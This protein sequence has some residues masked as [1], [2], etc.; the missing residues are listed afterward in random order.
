MIVYYNGKF[1]RKEEV[2]ISPDDRGFLFAD[3]VYDVIHA[4]AGRLFRCD[5]HLARFAHGM[6]ELR[7]KGVDSKALKEV[8]QQLLAENDLEKE[9]A[10]IYMQVTR[11]AAPRSHEFPPEGTP[12][13]VYVEAKPYSP[14][15]QLRENGAMAILVPDQRWSRCD[16]KSISLLPNILA[17]QKATEAGAFEA[18]FWGDGLL[19]EGTH[20][21]ILFVKGRRLVCP[22]LTN[23]LLPSV[24]RSV[25]I[26]LAIAESIRVD[27]R[28]CREGEL[29]E[30]DEI[31]MLGTGV[32]IVPITTINGRKIRHGMVG[33]ITRQLQSAFTRTVNSH[34]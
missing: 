17:H 10:L 28:P 18:I 4:Y 32:E 1:L 33:Q 13:T 22:A 21:S 19:H 12:S 6:G 27:E 14:P 9:E 11:G 25:V 23:R 30:F 20:S 8:S 7:I 34:A 31:L 16:I 29:L 3:G 15:R 26:E 2:A 24:T 5:E